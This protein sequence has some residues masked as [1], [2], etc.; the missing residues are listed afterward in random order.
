LP[1][2]DLQN[3]YQL[4]L[5]H[6]VDQRA[7]RE[8]RRRSNNVNNTNNSNNKNKGTHHQKAAHNVSS[9]PPDIHSISFFSSLNV[10]SVQQKCCTGLGQKF[11]LP[12]DFRDQ[13]Y[14]KPPVYGH[15]QSL[16]YNNNTTGKGQGH[17]RP[18]RLEPSDQSCQCHQQYLTT[19]SD[20]RNQ[21]DKK[22]NKKD[23]QQQK[24][25]QSL[26]QQKCGHDCFNRLGYTECIGN[27]LTPSGKKNKYWN[28]ELGVDCG[29]RALGRRQF[30]RCKVKRERGKGFGLVTLDGVK[31]GAY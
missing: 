22:G 3:S 30:A 20:T 31:K 8:E 16:Q 15:V 24:L 11:C 18:K 5:E 23:K 13:V 28:C 4:E 2:L 21:K 7:E 1:D 26:S 27:A 17:R 9:Y 6:K 14:A 10:K 12:I 29:N 25:P 19:D